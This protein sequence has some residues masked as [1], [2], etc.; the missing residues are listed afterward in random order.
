M[1][2]NERVVSTIVHF[3]NEKI[4]LAITKIHSSIKI[5]KQISLTVPLGLRLEIKT[6]A[7]KLNNIN[8]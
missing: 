3:K 5:P 1:V 8:E 4:I 2:D 6:N 7:A